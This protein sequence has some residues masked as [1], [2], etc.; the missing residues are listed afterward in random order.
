[1]HSE[2]CKTRFNVF[3]TE[4]P[5][6]WDSAWGMVRPNRHTGAPESFDRT[7]LVRLPD[8]KPWTGPG[9]L[10]QI[11]MDVRYNG[12]HPFPTRL[13][14]SMQLTALEEVNKRRLM[15]ARLQTLEASSETWTPS[16][17]A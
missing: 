1:M 6:R 8:E 13:M 12:Q 3:K 15:R 17:E 14:A 9:L 10:E 5:K 16:P 4:K 2:N 7:L 11:P